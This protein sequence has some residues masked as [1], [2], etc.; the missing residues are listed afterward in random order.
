MSSN[1]T[2]AVVGE[3]LHICLKTTSH[4]TNFLDSSYAAFKISVPSPDDQCTASLL[5]GEIVLDSESDKA[6]DYVGINSL[7]CHH[8]RKLVAK[9]R[10]SLAQKMRRLKARKLAERNF[11]A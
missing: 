2:S 4:H 6:E 8:V 1:K 3:F 11:L 9:K 7:A 5:N 10:A